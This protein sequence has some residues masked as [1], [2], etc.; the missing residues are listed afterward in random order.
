MTSRLTIGTSTR[1]NS[2]EEDE[3]VESDT[4][5]IVTFASAEEG[6][7]SPPPLPERSNKDVES[8]FSMKSTLSEESQ[9]VSSA[10]TQHEK[11]LKK[12]Q[13][14][15]RKLQEKIEK[16]AERAAAKKREDNDKDAAALAKLREKHER[17]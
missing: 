16:S 12:L 3:D 10:P 1:G 17:D 8:A 5:S 13:E 11:D 14:R 15:R 9:A 2:E 4:S 7:P 6:E